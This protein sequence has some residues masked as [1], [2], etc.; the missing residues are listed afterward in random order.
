[1]I[2]RKDGNI[3]RVENYW[4]S[5][6]QHEKETVYGICHKQKPPS[7]VGIE[8]MYVTK[9][10]AEVGVIMNLVSF[11]RQGLCIWQHLFLR[12]TNILVIFQELEDDVFTAPENSQRRERG[13]SYVRYILPLISNVICIFVFG[14]F[15]CD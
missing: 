12:K 7:N 10:S 9:D 15:R 1:M 2:E 8:E 11:T 5:E 13:L 3:G 6:E 4:K 14:L